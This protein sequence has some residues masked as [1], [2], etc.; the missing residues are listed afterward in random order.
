MV[1]LEFN[2][3]SISAELQYHVIEK[4]LTKTESILNTMMIRGTRAAEIADHG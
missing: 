3:D 4:A 1:N 2:E